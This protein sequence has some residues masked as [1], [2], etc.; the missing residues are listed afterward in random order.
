MDS[1]DFVFS[2]DVAESLGFRMDQTENEPLT[3]ADAETAGGSLKACLG[4][5]GAVGLGVVSF[6]S[7]LSTKAPL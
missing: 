1:N 4:S 7:D 6:L 5:F 3:T 2:D